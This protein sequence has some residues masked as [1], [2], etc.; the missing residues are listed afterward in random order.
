MLDREGCSFLDAVD[1]MGNRLWSR[2]EMP[3]TE[4]SELLKD[5]IPPRAAL[6]VLENISSVI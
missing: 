6:D 1:E 5:L 3:K 4:K 2:C